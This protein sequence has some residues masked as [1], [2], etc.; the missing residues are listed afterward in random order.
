VTLGR[1]Q[2]RG[3]PLALSSASADMS[4]VDG[5]GAVFCTSPDALTAPGVSVGQYAMHQAT[6]DQRDRG[7]LLG[8]VKRRARQ[9]RLLWRGVL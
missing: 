2:R 9:R 3:L 7:S 1:R 4:L 8:V 5:S 6:A